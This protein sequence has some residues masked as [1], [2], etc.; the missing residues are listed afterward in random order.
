[1]ADLAY[2]MS[3]SP[4]AVPYAGNFVPQE[5]PLLGRIV[6]ELS[7]PEVAS[8]YSYDMPAPTQTFDQAEV[9]G[10]DLA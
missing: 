3:A 1:M 7:Q 9:T 6:I 5:P 4:P 2:G 8:G 10:N